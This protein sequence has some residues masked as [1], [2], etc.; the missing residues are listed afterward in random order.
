MPGHWSNGWSAENVT[1]C[2][3][4]WAQGPIK[5]PE[6]RLAQVP[7]ACSGRETISCEILRRQRQK[8]LATKGSSE[9]ASEAIQTWDKVVPTLWR[10]GSG[11]QRHAH[12]QWANA[13]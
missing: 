13:L 9:Q 3:L 7:K 8:H 4:S 10:R 5:V 2:K 6:R 1:V 12:S 11:V